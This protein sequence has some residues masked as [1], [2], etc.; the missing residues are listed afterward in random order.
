MSRAGTEACPYDWLSEIRKALTVFDG[1]NPFGFPV[2][3]DTAVRPYAEI[4]H[5]TKFTTTNQHANAMRGGILSARAGRRKCRNRQKWSQCAPATSARA[6][7]THQASTLIVRHR[8]HQCGRT[9]R[10]FPYAE[11][12]SSHRVVASKNTK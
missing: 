12:L 11:V 8:I 10:T 7:G 1:L 6:R 2:W 9:R 5:V 3:A 4:V